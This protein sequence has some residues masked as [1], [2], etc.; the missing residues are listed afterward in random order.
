MRA[1]C[2]PPHFSRTTFMST[3]KVLGFSLFLASFSWIAAPGHAAIGLGSLQNFNSFPTTNE[4][5][6]AA[7]T[8]AAGDFVYAGLLEADVQGVATAAAIRFPLPSDPG[9]PPGANAAARWSSIGRNVTTRP[10]G[11][12]YT[13]LL[14]KIIND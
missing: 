7:R 12:A 3:S 6:T 5:T 2:H 8:G 13:V 11:V 9:N 4:W 10:T 14:A 1:S